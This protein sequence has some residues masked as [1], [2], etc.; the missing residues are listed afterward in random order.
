MRR[1]QTFKICANH[2][3]QSEIKLDLMKG[4]TEA[5]IWG[6]Q[7]FSEGEITTE[8]FCIKMKTEE[9]IEK[10]HA[11]FETAAKSA[12]TSPKK[13]EKVDVKA[14]AGKSLAD[15]AAAQKSGSWECGG[16]LT[17]NDNAKIQCLA[18][19]GP[20]PGCEEEVKKMKEATKPAATVMTIGAGGGFKFGGEGAAP[21]SSSG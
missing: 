2:T 16:C 15:F 7:D 17:R 4:N 10:F 12:V 9:Q 3:L 13:P 11:V 1:D 8:K 14:P 19:E 6:A 5:R 21:G 20:K 18:C